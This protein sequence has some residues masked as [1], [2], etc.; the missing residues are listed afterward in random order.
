MDP[1]LIGYLAAILMG[2]LLGILGGGGSV[3]TIP[4]LVYLFSV[5]ATLASSYSLWVVGVAATVGVVRCS[6]MKQVSYRVAFLFGGPSVL[7]VIVSRWALLPTIPDHLCQL[8]NVSLTR[9]LLVLVVF[10]ILMLGAGFS[11]IVQSSAAIGDTSDN[12]T[13]QLLSVKKRLIIILEGLLVGVLTG[14]VGAGGGFL[15]VP[16]LVLVLGLPIRIAIGTSL[17]IISVR[18]VLGVAVDSIFWRDAVWNFLLTFTAAAVFGIVLGGLLA[19]RIPS[20]PLKVSFGWFV[21]LLG[22]WMLGKELWL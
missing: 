8:G 21:L 9:D 17:A 11:M 19:Y 16:V 20:K 12:P 3:L 4:I 7:G 15:I 6:R 5:N 2:M 18:S 10:S 13:R 14:F 1:P 22:S